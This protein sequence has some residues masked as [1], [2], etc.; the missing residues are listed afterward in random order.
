MGPAVS[1][2]PYLLEVFPL[3][4]SRADGG[5]QSRDVLPRGGKTLIPL[6][7]AGVLARPNLLADLVDRAEVGVVHQLHE[8]PVPK[9][10]IG[11]RRPTATTGV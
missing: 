2:L 11:H 10:L 3:L 8:V 9:L 4:V 5:T 1:P 6:F 7:A